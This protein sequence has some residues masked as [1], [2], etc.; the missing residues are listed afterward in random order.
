MS[1]RRKLALGS[2]LWLSICGNALG[3]SPNLEKVRQ[4]TLRPYDGPSER[5]VDAS[6]LHGKVLCGYQGWFAAEGDGC[7]QGWFHWSKDNRV[8]TA[9]SLRVDLWPD[10]AELAPDERFATHV[11]FADGRRAEVFSSFKKATV[12]RHFA[13]MREFG[14]DGALVT[15]SPVPS[16]VPRACGTTTSCWPIAAKGPT[17]T[18][19]L[20][21][22]S[23]I[24]P[25]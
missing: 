11:K 14:I 2:I 21:P 24:S 3:Q 23:T 16:A 19:A 8:P 9:A 10:L 15:A 22:W 18:A 7:G 5:G 12:L 1:R 20:M 17:D 4:E 25:A 6:T 13:W